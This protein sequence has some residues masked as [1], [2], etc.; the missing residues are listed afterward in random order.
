MCSRCLIAAVVRDKKNNRYLQYLSIYHQLCK[1][2]QLQLH[3]KQ[4]VKHLLLVFS[5][6][7]E[8]L[9]IFLQRHALLL[10]AC[11]EDV[12]DF[13]KCNLQTRQSLGDFQFYES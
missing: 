3:E 13:D 12:M 10:E 2:K 6:L 7:L 8:G 11:N 1:M 9:K 4:S 5:L